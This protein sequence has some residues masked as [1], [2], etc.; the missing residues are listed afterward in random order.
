MTVAVAVRVVQGTTLV[1]ALKVATA[2]SPE[3]VGAAVVV[4][5]VEVEEVQVAPEVA[6]RQEEEVVEQEE[7]KEEKEEEGEE[8]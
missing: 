1:L 7:K 2:V 3:A 5:E 8:D 6:G 4:E